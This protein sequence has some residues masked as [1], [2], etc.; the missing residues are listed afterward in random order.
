MLQSSS[1]T[2]TNYNLF[3]S[4]KCLALTW[5]LRCSEVKWFA[6]KHTEV[7]ETL[8]SIS[9]QPSATGLQ[10]LLSFSPHCKIRA[11]TSCVF[12][13]KDAVSKG[14]TDSTNTATC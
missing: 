3:S 4:Q 6:E 11:L 5:Q 13:K 10:C 8:G 9:L 12:L 14:C 7:A 1:N 2:S